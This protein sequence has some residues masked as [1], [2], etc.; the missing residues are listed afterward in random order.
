M[1]DGDAG[2]K[3]MLLL[4]CS[5]GG[6]GGGCNFLGGCEDLCAGKEQ[7]LVESH[8]DNVRGL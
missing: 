4:V 1:V 3:E 6:G 7:R 5:C 2:H 8:L